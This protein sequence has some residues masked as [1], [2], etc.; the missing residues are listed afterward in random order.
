MFAESFCL[1]GGV[2]LGFPA[3]VTAAFAICRSGGRSLPWQGRRHS[4][5]EERRY[6]RGSVKKLFW[7]KAN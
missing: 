7:N 5:L 6:R 1:V 3:S 2:K 4:A